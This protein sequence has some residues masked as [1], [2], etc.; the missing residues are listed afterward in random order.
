M[1]RWRF[2][3]VFS[4]TVLS[5][6]DNNLSGPLSPTPSAA[7]PYTNMVRYERFSK[8]EAMRPEARG[9][10]VIMGPQAWHCWDL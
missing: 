1:A 7:A 2:D 6:P 3:K 5:D 4:A 10:I 9:L 8:Y